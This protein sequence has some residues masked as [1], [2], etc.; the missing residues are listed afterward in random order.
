[1]FYKQ[2]QLAE[3]FGYHDYSNQ[4]GLIAQEVK[5]ILPEAVTLAPFDI[6]EHEQSRTGENYLT[7]YYE[8]IIPLIVETIKTQQ[9][10]IELLKQKLNGI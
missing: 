4:V 1:M 8:R 2:N 9:K 5:G 10:E 3:T 6:D 7:I